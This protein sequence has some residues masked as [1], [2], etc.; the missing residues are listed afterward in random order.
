VILDAGSARWLLVLH[1]ALGVAAV[2]AST[3]LCVWLVKYLRG[4]HGRRR[5]VQRFAMIALCLHGAAFVVGNLAY[6]TYK[7]RVRAEYLDSTDAVAAD[8]DARL[9]ASAE[10]ERRE[11]GTA[12]TSDAEIAREVAAAPADATR[13]AR[14]FDSKEHWVAVGLALA[15]AVVALTRAW[16][17]ERDGR[18][19]APFV[20]MAA[21]AACATLWFAATVGVLTATWRAI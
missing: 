8:I 19:A 3:H 16:N 13:A 7:T 15:L 11:T 2:A 10:R 1:T 12:S 17:P 5:A 4:A 9:R 20:V 18:G 21:F 6:P 14:W